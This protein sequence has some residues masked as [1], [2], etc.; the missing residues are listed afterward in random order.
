MNLAVLGCGLIGGSAAMAWRRAFPDAEVA[1]FDVDPG[2]VERAFAAGVLTRS[3]ADPADAAVGADVVLVAAPVPAIAGL[4]AAAA[5]GLGPSAVV[6]DVGS[7]KGSV[8][9]Q[10]RAAAPGV[11]FVGGHPMAGTEQHGFAAARPDLFAGAWWFLTPDDA[12]SREAASGLA[13]ALR[14]LGAKV[15]ELEAEA[16]DRIVA[17]VSH[18]P[19]LV[20]AGLVHLAGTPID[21]EDARLFAGSGFRDMT[22]IADSN[23]QLW[24]EICL[25]NRGA[26]MESLAALATESARLER[27]LFEEDRIGLLAFLSGARDARRLLPDKADRPSLRVVGVEVPDSPGTLAAV[28]TLLGEAAVNIEDIRVAHSPSGERGWFFLTIRDEDVPGTLRTLSSRGYIVEVL[29]R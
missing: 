14:A 11:R 4:V 1:G 23:P 25:A 19:M 18:L 5:P 2:A 26:I 10:V 28:A 12:G 27:S 29:S 20:A 22:R 7:V 24:V 21:G 9:A 15:M 3:A 17:A 13:P 16:H 6:T 8:L